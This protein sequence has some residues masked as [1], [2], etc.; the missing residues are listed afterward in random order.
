MVGASEY[1]LSVFF[2][3]K[4]F[5]PLMRCRGNNIGLGERESQKQCFRLHCRAAKTQKVPGDATVDTMVEWKWSRAEWS[6]TSE[7]IRFRSKTMLAAVNNSRSD[8]Q[9]WF[10]TLDSL[11][12]RYQLFS[13]PPAR[14]HTQ[15][16]QLASSAA[17]N[18]YADTDKTARVWYQRHATL[19]SATVQSKSNTSLN[20]SHR[21][22]SSTFSNFHSPNI[23]R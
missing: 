13:L 18:R 11:K 1:F 14:R 12:S 2:S 9:R 5:K 8:R 17:V 16:L 19:H 20:L 7:E 23:T 21:S 3:K 10:G 22:S 6:K 4:L 15:P